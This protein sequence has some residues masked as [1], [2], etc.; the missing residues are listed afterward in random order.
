MPESEKTEKA[1]SFARVRDGV[2]LAQVVYRGT[3]LIG[4]T[5]YLVYCYLINSR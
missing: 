4:S 3:R 1:D 2:K 5:N